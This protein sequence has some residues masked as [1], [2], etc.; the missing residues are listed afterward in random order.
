MTLGDW[1]IAHS[2]ILTKNLAIPI[3]SPVIMN[4]AVFIGIGLICLMKKISRQHSI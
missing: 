2:D 3:L 1:D 4:E